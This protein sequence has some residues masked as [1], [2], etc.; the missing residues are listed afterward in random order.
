[1]VISFIDKTNQVS[2]KGLKKDAEVA[3]ER[4]K[5]VLAKISSKEIELDSKVYLHIESKIPELEKSNNVVI[6]KV[7]DK[8]KMSL[9][10]KLV[11]CSI[12]EDNVTSTFEYLSPLQPIETKIALGKKK[13]PFLQ[14]LSTF[15][16]LEQDHPSSTIPRNLQL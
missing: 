7:E 13:V 14:N 4:L 1:M 9:K 2:L 16:L 6:R 10:I 3:R 11:I 5:D 15:N 12:S 8:R